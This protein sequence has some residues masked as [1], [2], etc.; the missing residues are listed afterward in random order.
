[1]TSKRLL[2][3]LAT[4]L[5][6]LAGLAV[7]ADLPTAAPRVVG[8]L[9]ALVLPSDVAVGRNGRIY[10]VNGGQH[11]IAVYDATGTKVDALGIL[12]NDA[13][14]LMMPLALGIGRGG[15]VYVVD[16]GNNRIVP[17]D[18]EGDP[19][20]PLVLEE[21]GSEI[22]PV[23]VAVSNDG[24]ELFVTSNNTHRVV[25]FSNRGEF[26]RAWGGEGEDD[27]QFRFPAT[28][29]IDASGNVYVVDV[30]NARVQKFSPDGTHLMT[31]GERGG[32]AGT[33]FRPK[34]VAVDGTGRIYVSD[35]YLGVIQAFGPTGAFLYALGDGGTAAV[36]DTP[37]GI[38][39]AGA[40][41][42]VTQMLAGKVTVL[43]PQAPTARP[44]GEGG[45]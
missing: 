19:R 23:D 34:G 27:G 4:A 32:K 43:E 42:Y 36:F 39:A 21:D 33:F 18:A 38:A 5:T 1:M 12:G 2:K 29:D 41:L 10:V 20:R 37:A 15:E 6:A 3:V 26:L 44:T 40:R 17:F 11:E 14:Q 30:L 45:E 7:A 13:G 8:E 35:S 24:T 28:I 25:V 16:R 22:V 31:L 9:S